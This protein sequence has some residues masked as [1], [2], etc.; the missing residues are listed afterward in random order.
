M[1]KSNNELSSKSWLFIFKKYKKTQENQKKGPFRSRFGEIVLHILHFFTVRRAYC[2]RFSLGGFRLW[3]WWFRSLSWI[4]RRSPINLCIFSSISLYPPGKSRDHLATFPITFQIL[5]LLVVWST[6]SLLGF[7][8][9]RLSFSFVF[10]SFEA[11]ARAVACLA[12]LC[13]SR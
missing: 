11:S 1:I 2:W 10:G 8:I 12:Q 5:P 9:W 13:L 6:P 3:V 4:A 7:W